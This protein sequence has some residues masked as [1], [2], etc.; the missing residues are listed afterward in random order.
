MAIPKP[1]QKLFDQ[2]LHES[3]RESGSA[4]SGPLATI[5]AAKIACEDLLEVGDDKAKRAAEELKKTFTEMLDS[6]A[7]GKK[8][9]ENLY[10]TAA[11]RATVG[12]KG[13]PRVLKSANKSK[14]VTT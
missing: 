11:E 14:K 9:V 12:K 7:A 13:K 1:I 6:Y 10:M 2:L 4:F 3:L 8:A 5:M